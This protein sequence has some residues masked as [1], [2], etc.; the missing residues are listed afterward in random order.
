MELVDVL[1]CGV[2]KDGEASVDLVGSSC[3]HQLLQEKE[4]RYGIA[5]NFRINL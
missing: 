3:I 5:H 1:W 2:S 4:Q